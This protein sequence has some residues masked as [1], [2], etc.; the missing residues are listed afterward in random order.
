[1]FPYICTTFTTFLT[2]VGSRGREKPWDNHISEKLWTGVRKSMLSAS[3]D[4]LFVTTITLLG[5]FL[6]VT[7]LVF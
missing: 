4:I 1:M 5:G 2:T 7:L 3:C 6:D